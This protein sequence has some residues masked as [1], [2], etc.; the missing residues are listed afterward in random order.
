MRKYQIIDRET[1]GHVHGGLRWRDMCLSYNVEDRRPGA[2]SRREQVRQTD[3]LNRAKGCPTW[4]DLH[5][6][7]PVPRRW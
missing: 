6:G 5:P 1:L 7:R 4:S 2:P 3:E